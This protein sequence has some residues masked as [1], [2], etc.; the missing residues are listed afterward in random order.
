MLLTGTRS[1]TAEPPTTPP[2]LA[3]GGVCDQC[4]NPERV[5]L[6]SWFGDDWVAVSLCPTCD[7]DHPIVQAVLRAAADLL[8]E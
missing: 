3:S 8:A 2:E 7:P 6:R 1:V 4:G 5:E